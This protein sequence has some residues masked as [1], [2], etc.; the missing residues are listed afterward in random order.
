[1][2]ALRLLHL[3]VAALVSAGALVPTAAAAAPGRTCGGEAATIVGTSGPDRL[4]GSPGRDVI[5]GLGGRDVITGRGGDDL[6]CGGRGA[7][8]LS[9]GPGD[10]RLYGGLDSRGADRAGVFLVGDVLRGGP[11][12]DLLDLGDDTR[13]GHKPPDTVSYDAA[14]GPVVVDLSGEGAGTATGQGVDT[15]VL[16]TQAAVVG[17]AFDDTITG[18]TRDD[19]LAGGPGDDTVLG[20]AGNDTLGGDDRLGPDDHVGSS[21]PPVVGETDDDVVRGGAGDDVLW[22]STGRDELHGDEDNDAIEV[23]GTDP[24]AV[25]GGDGVDA[26]DQVLATAAGGSSDGGPGHDYLTVFGTPYEGASPRTRYTLDLRTGTSSVSS[27]ASVTGAVGGYE[28]YRLMGRLRWRFFGTPGDD[29]VRA[30]YGGP[31]W[32]ATFGGDDYL[33]GTTHADHLDGGPGTDTADGREAV[34]TCLDIEKGN[35]TC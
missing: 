34:D 30:L 27:D 22:S 2:K 12:D 4:A 31:L 26:V 16:S 9:G 25:F 29:R 11:G 17:S 33:I 32:A 23:T 28:E 35:A 20:G 8:T 19:K 21:H 24:T 14:T 15:I 7:D 5:V 18:S 6:V 10:D 13:R 3:S 1:M